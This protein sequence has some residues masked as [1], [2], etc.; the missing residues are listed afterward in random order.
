M[1]GRKSGSCP[2]LARGEKKEAPHYNWYP[3]EIVAACLFT[4]SFMT[5]TEESLSIH[6]QFSCLIADW[7]RYD[8]LK[9]R[10]VGRLVVTSDAAD[11]SSRRGSCLQQQAAESAASPGL[12]HCHF[13]QIHSSG[14]SRGNQW[15]VPVTGEREMC[16][17]AFDGSFSRLVVSRF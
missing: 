5:I 1:E 4:G 12:S 11:K 6:C 17:S 14:M 15:T 13:Q 7:S 16:L 2:C 10:S 3:P 8:W 9:L